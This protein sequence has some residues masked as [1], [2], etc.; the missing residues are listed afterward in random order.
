LEHKQPS[1]RLSVGGSSILVIFVILTLTTFA[2]LSLVSAQADSKLSEKAKTAAAQ[3]YAADSRAEEVFAQ[4][5]E[6]IMLTELFTGADIGDR[7]IGDIV[8]HIVQGDAAGVFTISYTVPINEIQ[9][10]HVELQASAGQLTRNTWKV[11]TD[12][13][14]EEPDGLNLWFDEN[15]G[16]AVFDGGFDE[17]PDSFTLEDEDNL[18]MLD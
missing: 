11:V 12:P 14:E 9:E 13:G 2:T 3:Y 18:V 1:V 5:K 15:V 6:S 7:T 10:L 17:I 4:I 16:F 8:I